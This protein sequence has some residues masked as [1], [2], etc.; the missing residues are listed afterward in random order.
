VLTNPLTSIG[1]AKADLVL[2]DTKVS[3]RHGEFELSPEGVIYRDTGSTNGSLLN[4]RAVTSAVL[5]PGDVLK[6]GETSL[7]VF[8]DAA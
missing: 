6:L 7:T 4:G 2:V 3:R 5:K 8:R 1:R